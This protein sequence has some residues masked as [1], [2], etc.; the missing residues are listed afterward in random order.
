MSEIQLFSN[1]AISLLE[2][3][4]LSNSTSIQVQS[5]LGSLFPQPNANEFFLI[6][7][8]DIAAPLNRE[9]I[10]IVSVV[11]DTLIVSVDGRGYEN[12]TPREW[13]AGETLVD[14]RIT[15]GTI[16]QAFLKPEATVTPPTPLEVKDEGVTLSDNVTSINFIGTGVTSYIAGNSV[17]VNIPGT[18]GGATSFPPVLVE[19]AWTNPIAQVSYADLSRSNKFWITLTSPTN[20]LTECFEILSVIQG[21]LSTDTE[22]VTWTVTNR[23]GNKF[24]GN[25]ILRLDRPVNQLI[26]EWTN[27]EPS[28]SIIATAVSL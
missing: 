5:G 21:L 2:T 28:L 14:H 3:S 8:E 18:S 27:N 19:P 13:E 11:G 4:L 15:A 26:L 9:I 1:N 12:T 22:T 10:K 20:G 24:L 6:T 23:I 17:N 7:L 16:R 25:M